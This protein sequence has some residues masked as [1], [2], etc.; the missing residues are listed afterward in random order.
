MLSWSPIP[1]ETPAETYDV[2]KGTVND[3]DISLKVVV[4]QGS[5]SENVEATKKW[6]YGIV[7]LGNTYYSE[8]GVAA[9][10]GTYELTGEIAN[11]AKIDENGYLVPIKGTWEDLI[12]A[13]KTKGQKTGMVTCYKQEAGKSRVE[14]S[15][16]V[17]IDFR[18]DMAYIDQHEKT[19]NVVYTDNSFTNDKKN[20]WTGDQTTD[21]FKLTAHF[22]NEFGT[23]AV[24]YTHL[25]LPTT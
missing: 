16:K 15:Y 2:S 17:T 21:P 13:N 1:V 19:F 9:N 18:Y 20:N 11:F 24:S 22:T 25:T 10:Q 6:S 12:A 3:R 14:D 23:S 5:K 4:T 8:N 7:K